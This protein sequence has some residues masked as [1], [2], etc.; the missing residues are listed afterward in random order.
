MHAGWRHVI[1]TLWSVWDTT[2]ATITQDL[3]PQLIRGDGLDPTDTAHA[4][5]HTIRK[6]RDTQPERPS[7]WAPFIHIGP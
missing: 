4:L 7:T 6:L 3:Y 5:H 2:A 1:G